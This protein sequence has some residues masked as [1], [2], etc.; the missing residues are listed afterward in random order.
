MEGKV[1]IHTSAVSAFKIYSVLI[2]PFCTTSLGHGSVYEA[3]VGDDEHEDNETGDDNE[4]EGVSPF[5]QD[6][7]DPKRQQDYGD[8]VGEGDGDDAGLECPTAPHL[9]REGHSGTRTASHF[10]QFCV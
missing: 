9:R 5:D 1:P 7:H 4:D 10:A 8:H 6:L 3:H 2:C